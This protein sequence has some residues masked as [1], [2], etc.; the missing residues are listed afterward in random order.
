MTKKELRSGIFGLERD[1]RIEGIGAFP[2]VDSRSW[3]AKPLL[4][5]VARRTISSRWA[6][7]AMWV[8]VFNGCWDVGTKSTRVAANAQRTSSAM[9]RCP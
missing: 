6:A 3:M 2:R 1:D 4:S 5:A 7:V 9:P 8:A